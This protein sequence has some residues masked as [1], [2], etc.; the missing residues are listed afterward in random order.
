MSER[1]EEK[2][3]DKKRDEDGQVCLIISYK[4]NK[5]RL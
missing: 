4:D 1:K 3:E 5:E 2:E